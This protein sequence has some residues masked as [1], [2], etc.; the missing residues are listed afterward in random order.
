VF[1][2]FGFQSGKDNDKF[3]GYEE[4]C[5]RSANGLYYIEQNV[6][7]FMSAKVISVS[8]CGS[9]SLF[10]AEVQEAIVLSD[11]PSLSYQYYFD[12]IKPKAAAKPAAESKKFVYVCKIC[13]YIYESDTE[14]PDDYVCPLCKHGKEVFELKKGG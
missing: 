1:K 2:R 3:A 11:E 4:H 5:K 12:N 14:M 10:V 8:N 6:N 9:H 7:A 13:G